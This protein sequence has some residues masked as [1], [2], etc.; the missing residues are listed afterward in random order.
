MFAYCTEVLHLSEAEAYLR[1]TAAAPRGSTRCSWRCC[2]D[3][4]LHLTAIAK[5][6]PHLT[7]GEPG[8]AP[9]AGRPPDQARDRGAGRG[10]GARP[11]CSA[12]VR[13]LP[14]RRAGDRAGRRP[15][16]TVRTEL[17]R[18]ALDR[19]TEC[20]A[21]LGR[22]QSRDAGPDCSPSTELPVP[23]TWLGPGPQPSSPSRRPAT[24]SSSPPAPSS[25]TSSSGS[26]PSCAPRCPTA[27]WPRSSS[28]PSPRS[29][30]GSKRGG[31][32]RTKRPEEGPLRRAT[33]RPS[34]RHIP[35]A[36]RRAVYER[37]G[38]RCRYVDEQGRRC[39]ARDGLE[40]H[41]RHP[42]A[43]G[44]DHDP[45]GMALMCRTHNGLLAEID[46]GREAVAKHRRSH[47]AS[48][49]L[50]VQTQSLFSP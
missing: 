33:R 38:G 19:R 10:A 22:R 34:S 9:G 50:A 32:R 45:D 20:A 30:S 21:E 6:A 28:R 7:A 29:S 36:V 26:R 24:R 1:I 3:G 40:F 16:D 48:R 27:T 44:G 14:E 41:H 47:T 17:A 25:A 13:K 12:V 15:S 2:A 31:S 35:A 8:D 23:R 43:Y 18:P 11:G 49:R 42:F 39:T 5:L 46:F 4:R 37:D